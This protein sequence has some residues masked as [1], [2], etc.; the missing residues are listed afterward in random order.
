MWLDREGESKSGDAHVG[1]RA[2]DLHPARRPAEI[3]DQA[4]H[5]E[6]GK[7]EQEQ[8]EWSRQRRVAGPGE[9][10]QPADRHDRCHRPEEQGRIER[11]ARALSKGM[12]KHDHK[13]ADEQ[14]LIDEA[15]QLDGTHLDTGTKLM[16]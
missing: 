8:E 2:G 13:K 3:I 10:C 11:G 14:A 6:G 9:L 15:D 1:H 12:T 5:G 4:N 7:V 16:G